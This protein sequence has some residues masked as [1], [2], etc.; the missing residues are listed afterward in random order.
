[1][2]FGN[3][4]KITHQHAA[5]ARNGIQVTSALPV[6][7]KILPRA[8]AAPAQT[9]KRRIAMKNLS[10]FTRAKDYAEKTAAQRKNLENRKT[11]INLAA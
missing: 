2:G 5:P 6:T 1:M 7:C 11:A 8:R 3:K 10:H 4:K 9:G